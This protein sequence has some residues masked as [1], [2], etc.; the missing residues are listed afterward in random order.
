MH[1][2]SE[3]R[4]LRCE[5]ENSVEKKQVR[6]RVTERTGKEAQTA[7]NVGWIL[8]EGTTR[9]RVSVV[10]EARRSV[11]LKFQK[12]RGSGSLPRMLRN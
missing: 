11:L 12:R 2:D 7:K 8:H 4:V 5:G 10:R 6:Q 9:E 1:R 3:S